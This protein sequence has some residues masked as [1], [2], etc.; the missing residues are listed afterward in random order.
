M[1]GLVTVLHTAE[2]TTNA[3]NM[4]PSAPCLS[5]IKENSQKAGS[6]LQQV[7]FALA[8]VLECSAA[9]GI[10]LRLP[11]QIPSC[12]TELQ[13]KVRSQRRKRHPRAL[14]LSQAAGCTPSPGEEMR[15]EA[16]SSYFIM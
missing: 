1:P 10:N 15:E 9:R 13:Q 8:E 12:C 7:A 4:L 3:P 6:N 16:A 5:T 14:Q 11:P 2:I